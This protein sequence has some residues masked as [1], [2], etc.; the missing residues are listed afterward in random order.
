MAMR[1]GRFLTKNME[2]I[3]MSMPNDSF[4]NSVTIPLIPVHEGIWADYLE[5]LKKMKAD[6]VLLFSPLDNICRTLHKVRKDV[7]G[8]SDLEPVPIQETSD[9]PSL[10]LFKE[11]SGMLKDRISYFASHNIE[12]AFWIGHTI[13]H[14][15]SLSAGDVPAFQQITGPEGMEAEG[16]FCPLD[17]N[18]ADYICKALAIMAGSGVGLILL[19]DDFRLNSHKPAAPV[20]CFCP[21]HIEAFNK[22]TGLMFSREEIVKQALQGRPNSIRKAW[23]EVLGESLLGFADKIEKSVHTVNP[24]ARIG[25]ATAMTLWDNEGVD[26]QH[27]LKTLAGITKPFLRT[28]GAPYWAKELSQ[29]SWVI[30]YTRLQKSWTDE[31][32]IEMAAEG[33]TFPHT[34]YHCPAA[35]LHSYQQGLHAAGFP[36]IISYPVVYSPSPDH[37][38]GYVR[39]YEKSI[40]HYN[41]LRRFF[42]ANYI[43]MGVTPVYKPNNF[44]NVV[45]PENFEKSTIP[46]PDEPVALRY[47]SRLGIPLAY[48]NTEGPVL[49]SGYGAAGLTDDEL[50]NLLNRG[51]VLDAT[52]ANWLSQKGIDVG[53]VASNKG[54]IPKFENFF[55]TEFSGKYSGQY[56]WLLTAADDIYQCFK[57]RKEVRVLSSFE[58]N[59]EE[60]HYPAVFIY[61]NAKAQR[62]CVLSFDFFNSKNNMQLVYN[63]ARQ[64]Q[65]TRCLT[66]VNKKPVSVTVNGEPDVHV[67]CRKSPDSNRIAVGIRNS[68]LDAINRPELRLDP[69]LAIGKELELLMPEA[70]NKCMTSDF[71]Y[72][73]DGIYG[74]L[75][76]NCTIPPM[77]LLSVGLPG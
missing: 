12:T 75:K 69:D 64:E 45:M 27:L 67:I 63:Y 4:V 55:D 32:D 58:G 2:M 22:K 53:I 36:G 56:I 44:I 71:E 1:E 30:E 50:Q 23:L 52:A 48:N 19:D 34:R 42:P 31:W 72:I 43:D 26:M 38:D 15:G 10:E 29:V 66:W 8:K 37:E 20:G 5:I 60:E 65:L 11:W 62:F 57:T 73:N 46:W 54:R 39:M 9:T 74:Y 18:F 35:I 16:C 41:S 6:R 51:V 77:G 7:S 68:H 59:C 28:I 49:L 17:S 21:L 61:E 14:G 76:L 13:G 24:Q 40:E 25:L 3:K 33:D 70:G 47:L